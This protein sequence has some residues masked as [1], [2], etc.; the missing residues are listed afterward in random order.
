MHSPRGFDAQQL[1]S[2]YESRLNS[3]ES[4]V[5]TENPMGDNLN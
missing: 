2:G 1:N 3:T 4:L 5:F